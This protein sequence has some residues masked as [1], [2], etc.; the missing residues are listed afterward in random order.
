MCEQKLSLPG[1][2]KVRLSYQSSLP[3]TEAALTL[4]K[5]GAAGPFS[6]EIRVLVPSQDAFTDLMAYRAMFEFLRLR[7]IVPKDAKLTGYAFDET[8]V[9]A[10]VIPSA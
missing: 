9:L 4:Q 10:Y 3:H 8:E 7:N 5:F 6:E 2:V 1:H